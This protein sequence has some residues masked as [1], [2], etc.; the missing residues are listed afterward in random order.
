LVSH[1]LSTM[2]PVPL[3]ELILTKELK[4]GLLD[5]GPIRLES[6]LSCHQHS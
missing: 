5:F 4:W 6:Q 2:L 3:S 1:T